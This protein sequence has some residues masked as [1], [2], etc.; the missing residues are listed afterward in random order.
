MI[1]TFDKFNTIG[2]EAEYDIIE[3]DY[4]FERKKTAAD[5][6]ILGTPVVFDPMQRAAGESN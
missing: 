4:E 2:T 6:D 3:R 5:F 1:Q